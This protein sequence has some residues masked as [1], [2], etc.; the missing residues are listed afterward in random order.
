MDTRTGT[1]IT[2][3]V[4]VI[5]SKTVIIIIEVKIM[6]IINTIVD[7]Y[8]ESELVAQ[9]SAEALHMPLVLWHNPM[10]ISF[11]CNHLLRSTLYRRG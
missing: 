8:T 1:I 2:I 6:T 9:K 3:I 4:L 5:L 7:R 10:E 11:G